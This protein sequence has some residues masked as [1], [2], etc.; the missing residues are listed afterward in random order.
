MTGAPLLWTVPSF[1]SAQW[2]GPPLDGPHHVVWVGADIYTKGC[3][4]QE[5]PPNL[6]G[7]FSSSILQHLRTCSLSLVSPLQGGPLSAPPYLLAMRA[8]RAGAAWPPSL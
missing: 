2:Q 5:S 3:L 7:Q 6:A 4:L 1:S 8:S